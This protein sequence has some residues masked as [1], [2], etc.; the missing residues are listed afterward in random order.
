VARETLDYVLRDML[1]VAGGFYSAEDADSVIDPAKPTEKAEGAFYVWTER[2]IDEILASPAAEYFRYRFGVER[3]GNVAEDPHG[4]F[5]G[6]NILFEARSIEDTAD[7]F[8]KSAEEIEALL[9]E[10]KQKLL[11]ARAGRVRPHLDDK[12][13][14][15]WNG[16]MI[17]AFAKA[18]AT[19]EEPRYSEAA[20][21]AADFVLARMY[22]PKSGSLLR[23]YRRED[24]AIP[25]FLDDY[26][27]F[28][29]GLLDLYEAA[30]HLPDLE[31]A[32]R[33]TEKQLALFEDKTAGGLFSTAEGDPS[34]ILRMKDDYD[35]AEPSGNAIAALNLLRLSEMTDR[36]DFREAASRILRVFASRAGSQPAAVPQLLAAYEFTLS[37]P[38]QIILIGGSG[39]GE[40]TRQLHSRFL[41]HAVV[42]AGVDENSGK[43]LARY[44]PVVAGMTAIGGAATAYVCENYACQLPTAEPEKFAEL[45]AEHGAL[46]Q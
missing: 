21:R 10:S 13:L 31:T 28:T 44:L 14:T 11:A 4:E 40:L 26:A 23:R 2:E 35:G 25:G 22:D 43:S 1:D 24:A 42:L 19:L 18:G 5:P 36:A 39:F 30:F 29:Q 17:S 15:S 32:I 16:L 27:F 33:L 34:L 7:H 38:K 8:G 41:P 3:D 20:R 9:A 12:E 6:K 46:I 37:R 45:L